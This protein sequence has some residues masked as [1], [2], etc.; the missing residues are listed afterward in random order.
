MLS[1]EMASLQLAHGNAKNKLVI[2]LARI[3]DTDDFLINIAKKPD[4]RQVELFLEE[5]DRALRF[6]IYGKLES[7]EGSRPLRRIGLTRIYNG[8]HAEWIVRLKT[9]NTYSTVTLNQ[10]DVDYLIKIH[11]SL[12]NDYLK[13]E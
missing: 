3:G 5:W 4:G 9:R 8:D 7:F 10:L 6:I 11:G 2:N 12:V 13:N 1:L